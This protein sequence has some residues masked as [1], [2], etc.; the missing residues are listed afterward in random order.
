M[1]RLNPAEV[2]LGNRERIENFPA[3]CEVL[4]VSGGPEYQIGVDDEELLELDFGAVALHAPGV[5]A[6]HKPVFRCRHENEACISDGAY[7]T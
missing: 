3:V 2:S 5:G 1:Q 7:K 6:H 4:G